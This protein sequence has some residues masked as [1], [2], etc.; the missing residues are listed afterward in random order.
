MILAGGGEFGNRTHGPLEVAQVIGIAVTEPVRIV[1][2]Q[3]AAGDPAIRCGEVRAVIQAAEGVFA[4]LPIPGFLEVH[5]VDGGP[6]RGVVALSGARATAERS[7]RRGLFVDGLR[8]EERATAEAELNPVEKAADVAH[9]L[10]VDFGG[11]LA[12]Q[13]VIRRRNGSELVDV[14]RV[15]GDILEVP[16]PFVPGRAF[17]VQRMIDHPAPS[18][19]AGLVEGVYVAGVQA[20]QLLKKAERT[21]DIASVFFEGQGY[22]GASIDT[23]RPGGVLG[24]A[25]ADMAGKAAGAVDGGFQVFAVAGQLVEKRVAGAQFADLIGLDSAVELA[26]HVLDAMAVVRLVVAVGGK[27]NARP[28]PIRWGGAVGELM[29]EHLTHRRDR[30]LVAR[31]G[32]P[33]DQR[34]DEGGKKHR[35]VVLPVGSLESLAVENRV[36]E[37]DLQAGTVAGVARH[38]VLD[39]IPPETQH[40][41]ITEVLLGLMPGQQA[42]LRV[43]MF[44]D[45]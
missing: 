11:V 36:D 23:E 18:R 37:V 22:A 42:A 31:V 3:A 39:K 8:A 38:L 32:K 6:A 40:L 1:V 28:V 19:V 16:A 24:V 44:F 34:V 2:V 41:V 17:S 4:G 43:E 10:R 21:G 35:R 12:R 26:R 30:L 15:A 25:G 13:D 20:D 9:P 29:V 14:V 27:W 33:A 45:C 7:I 5:G